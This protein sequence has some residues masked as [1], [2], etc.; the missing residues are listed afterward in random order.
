MLPLVTLAALLTTASATPTPR[1]PCNGN[2]DNCSLAALAERAGKVYFGDAWQS[3]YLAD[4]AF[5]PIL[6]SQFNQY[7]PENEMKWEVVHPSRDTYNWT[8]AD[9]VG[10]PLW[11]G[12]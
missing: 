6:E 2:G 1:W 11:I 7:T 3:F 5:G 8:G 10:T 4:K 9:L 12:R